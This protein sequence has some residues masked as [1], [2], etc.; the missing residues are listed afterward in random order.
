MASTREAEVVKVAAV[1]QGIAL[2]TF[3]AASGV[4]TS[5]S[6]Y[7]LSST[8][9]GAMFIPQAVT[10]VTAALLGATW[11]RRAGTR[12]VYLVGLVANLVAMTRSSSARRSRATRPLPTRS[13]CWQPPR[14]GSGSDSP[15]P[16]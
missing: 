15:C 6:E 11:A 3:P 12:R 14:S 13:C 1:V 10:A 2:V 8:A 4:F 7:D 5:A 9:Y 16:R